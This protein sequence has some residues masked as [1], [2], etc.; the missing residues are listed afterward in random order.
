MEIKSPEH[1]GDNATAFLTETLI[2]LSTDVSFIFHTHTRCV[3]IITY[4]QNILYTTR[5]ERNPTVFGG[6]E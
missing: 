4:G 6:P 5:R 1:G 2:I 3:Y